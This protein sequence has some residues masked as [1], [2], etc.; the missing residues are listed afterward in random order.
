MPLQKKKDEHAEVEMRINIMKSKLILSVLLK[1][2]VSINHEKKF[3][4]QK[5][6]ERKE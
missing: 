6:R 2:L 3:E 1:N 5:K 4:M